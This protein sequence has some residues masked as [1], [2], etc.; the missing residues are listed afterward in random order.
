MYNRKA[1]YAVHFTW[2]RA[3]WL[4]GNFIS[5]E[6][7]QANIKL[8]AYH[9]D[10]LFSHQLCAKKPCKPTEAAGDLMQA[11]GNDLVSHITALL[12]G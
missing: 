8:N 7:L 12:G 1:V 9:R 4:Q 5:Q 3:D 11:D 2:T 10:K 6:V